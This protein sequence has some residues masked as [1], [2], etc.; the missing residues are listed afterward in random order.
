M[1]L[2][3]GFAPFSRIACNSL[4]VLA[5]ASLL[6]VGVAAQSGTPAPMAPV[7]QHDARVG[8]L[9]DMLGKAR[10]PQ[11]AAISPNGQ[12]VA[13]TVGGRAGGELHVT[14]LAP[15]GT[16][17]DGAWDRVI[18]PDT[19]GNVTNGKPGL[20]S[21]AAPVWSPDGKQLAFLSDCT[22][23][24]ATWEVGEQSQFYVWTLA[25]NGMRQISDFTGTIDQPTWSPDG[26]TIGF[27]FV[28]NATRSAGALAAMKPWSGVIGEDGVEVQRVAAVDTSTGKMSYLT[29]PSLHV[30]E[31]DWA[32][33][34]LDGRLGACHALELGFVFDTLAG[35][36]GLTGPDAPQE[37]ADAMH[38]AWVAFATSGDPGWAPYT[39]AKRTTGVITDKITVVDDP[40]GDERATWDGIR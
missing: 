22:R 8:T 12:Y 1:N 24:G 33:S 34:L 18:S 3:H 36:R 39:R 23:K 25:G 37:L 4:A 21:G 16:A 38:S 40:D 5:T 10:T 27:L 6:C 28:E 2:I 14:G 35:A 31:F 32:S 20:C 30:Y 26:K 17:Q 11:V 15:E 9:L 13:W 7:K 29:P 19:I